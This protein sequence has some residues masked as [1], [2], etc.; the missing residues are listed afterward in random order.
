LLRFSFG[1]YN[2]DADIQRLA[3]LCQDWL[4]TRPAL[5]ESGV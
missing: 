3:A 2:N 1:I 5:A 4:K